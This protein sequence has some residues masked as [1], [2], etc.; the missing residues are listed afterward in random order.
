[1]LA[2]IGKE[3]GVSKII[4]VTKYG[5]AAKKLSTMGLGAN[6]I[7]VSDNIESVRYLNSLNGISGYYMG[8]RFP[9]T[10]IDHFIA[11]LKKLIDEEVISA[12]DVVAIAGITYPKIKTKLN[13]VAIYR[14]SDID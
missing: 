8:T 5:F 7:A 2:R 14:M 11:I 1:M 4:L 6:I 9:K 3:D 10:G 13:T 12:N